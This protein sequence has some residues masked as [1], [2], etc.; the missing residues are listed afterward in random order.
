[1]RDEEFPVEALSCRGYTPVFSGQPGYNGVAILSRIPAREIGTGLAQLD[2][3]QKRVLAATYGD[4]RLWNLY[5]PNGQSVE[6][7]KYR[8]K[9]DWL[10][11]LRTALE[12]ELTR[13]RK[14]VV[15]GD[16]NIAPEDRDVH[17][18][19]KWQGRVHCTPAERA[20]LGAVTALGFYDAFRLFEQPDR[21]YSWWDYRAGAF[22]RN[23]GLRIDL[24]LASEALR[25]ICTAA[26][27]DREPRGWERPSD[28]VPV[29]AEFATG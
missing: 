15:V 1:V 24:V 2:D 21:S 12:A 3:A 27:I 6:S 13:Y 4:V 10:A 20:A 23:Q 8:Y 7:E 29:I 28:H 18:P 14:V 9:L 5:V 19:V 16:F 22:R 26:H 11:A 25:Q 17:D